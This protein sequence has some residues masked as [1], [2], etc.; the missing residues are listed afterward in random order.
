MKSAVRYI[1]L[2]LLGSA[3]FT[4]GCT[5]VD[6][7]MRDCYDE[8]KLE[9]ELKLVTNMTTE[10]KTQLYL[11]SEKDVAQAL[12]TYLSDVFTDTAKDLDLS[13]YDVTGDSA[14]LYHESLKMDANQ[15]SHTLS[16]PIR[17]YMHTVLANLDSD[18]QVINEER[19]HRAKIVRQVSDT[20]P[21]L[22]TGTFSARLPMQMKENVDQEFEVNLYMVNSAA[23]FVVDTTGS[24]IKDI[25][26]FMSG[27]A[28]E[29]SV[30]DS[31]YHY[32]SSPIVR[33]DKIMHSGAD[34][35]CFVSVIFPSKDTQESKASTEAPLW[36]IRTYVTLR[37][38]SITETILGFSE[39]LNAAQ[40]K[41]VKGKAF[42]NGSVSPKDASVSVIVTL[43]WEP[44]LSGEIV[45]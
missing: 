15:L 41:I 37:D 8:S 1:I 19:C 18:M 21:T 4:V 7:D 13:F 35:L 32:D 25:K 29:F 24:G 5:L 45:F 22:K 27:F 6:E 10:I 12:E 30:C 38:G 43:N 16:I 14:R 39:P 2:F 40:L 34:P 33:T 44:G 26:V 3:A 17:D 20:I 11:E 9:Y 42:D 31:I 23:A 36:Q 28:T